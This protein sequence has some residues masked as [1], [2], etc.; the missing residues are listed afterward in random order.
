MIPTKGKKVKG[1]EV[2]EGNL[3]VEGLS[4]ATVDEMNNSY[5]S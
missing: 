4:E 2:Y 1:R 5:N 3:G